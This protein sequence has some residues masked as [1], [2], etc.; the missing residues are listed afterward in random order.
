MGQFAPGDCLLLLDRGVEL[1]A[2]PRVLAEL[3]E[4]SAGRLQ[5]LAEDLAARGLGSMANDHQ[6][7][8]IDSPGWVRLIAAHLQV[9]SWT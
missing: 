9:L 5:V 3:V 4:R 2:E 7:L 1:L 8:L 6:E